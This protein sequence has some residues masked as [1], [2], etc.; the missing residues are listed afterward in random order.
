[1]TEA[2]TKKSTKKANPEVELSKVEMEKRRTEVTS[3]YKDNIE[4]LKI[5]LEYETLLKDIEK[6]RAERVQAQAYLAQ[7]MAPPP[8]EEESRPEEPRQEEQDFREA[9]A[10]T[11]IPP[12][13]TLKRTE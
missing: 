9:M 1:M 5:Q 13:R 6:T 12:R 4:H 7:A 8:I 11:D 10:A 3:Y 2:K